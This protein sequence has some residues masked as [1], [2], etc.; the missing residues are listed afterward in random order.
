MPAITSAK[1]LINLNILEVKGEQFVILKKAYLDELLTLMR[2]FEAGERMLRL[3]KARSF[4][5][6]L[7]SIPKK[8]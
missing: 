6:F 8:R 1:K 5:E 7:K 2:S 4:S 3:G